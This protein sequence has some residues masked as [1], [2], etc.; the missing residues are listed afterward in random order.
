MTFA[1]LAVGIATFLSPMPAQT[2]TFA[3]PID[4]L[5]MTIAE[6]QHAQVRGKL[7][8]GWSPWQDFTLENE[9]DPSLTESNLILFDEAVSVI[10]LRGAAK[11]VIHPIRISHQPTSYKVAASGDSVVQTRILS[12]DEW[13]ADDGLLYSVPPSSGGSSSVSSQAPASNDQATGEPSQREKDCTEAQ[14]NYPDEFRTTNKVTKGP[15]GKTLR[16]A[17]TYSKKVSLLVVHHTAIQVTGDTRSGAE[18]VRALYQYHSVN[19]GWG[20]VGYHYLIDD[21]GMIYEGKSGGAYVV[22]GHAYCNNVNTV[23]IA[24]LGNFEIEEPTQAQ[25]KSLQWLLNDLATTYDIDVT[26]NTSYH[27]VP[28]PPIVGHG[29]VLSTDCPGYYVKKTLDQVRSHVRSGDLTASIDFP[30]PP[31]YQ[32][33][34]TKP[35]PSA[36]PEEASEDVTEATDRRV[37]RLQR[38]IRTAVR[39]STRVGGRAATLETI[40]RQS[41]PKQTAVIRPGRP[42]IVTRASSSP[43]PRSPESEVS[44]S[45]SDTIRVRLTRV[46][47]NLSAC[48]EANLTSLKTR[49]RGT[50]TCQTIDGRPALIN[51]IGIEDYLLGLGEEPDT[52]PYQKQRAFAI[53]ARSYVTYYSDSNHRKFPGQPYDATDDPATFQ[54]YNGKTFESDNPLWVKAVKS[55]SELVLTKNDSVVRAPYFSSDDGKTKSPEQAGWKNFPFAEVFLSKEDPWCSGMKNAGHGVGMSGCGSE[56]QANEGKT[57]EEILRYYYPGT[58]LKKLSDL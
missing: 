54:K 36:A 56:G 40:R 35:P 30:P 24:M 38:K 19:R 3:E 31:A 23:G 47:A 45:S 44:S 29:D 10:E 6:G 13:G 2:V 28:H 27:G 51:T 42:T 14:T 52:E 4:A 26:K 22:G 16:W 20:D 53:A 55:T 39:L 48:S 15:N 25:M 43:I 34:I 5:S 41:T 49:Y 11:E 9:Q 18:K 7:Q 58:T 17:H 8:S 37:G 46:D 57:G 50:V 1:S 32:T 12:R 33:P 21:K